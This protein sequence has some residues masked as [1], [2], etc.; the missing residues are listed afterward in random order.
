MQATTLLKSLYGN[1]GRTKVTAYFRHFESITYNWSD[2]RRAYL[3]ADHLEGDAQN[4]FES[5]G[6]AQQESYEMIKAAILTSSANAYSLRSRAQN[7]VVNGI[8]Q[9][10]GESL[11]SYG[12]RVLST[13][14]DSMLPDTP[15]E[16]VEDT[17]ACQLL[18]HIKDPMIHKILVLQRPNS[19]FHQLLDTAVTLS[20]SSNS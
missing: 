9:R 4:T 13:V 6:P 1:E 8:Q 14:R 20:E 7:E 10:R 12:R 3:I 15:K 5:L 17:A 16:Q 18:H 2:R 11:M 19:T